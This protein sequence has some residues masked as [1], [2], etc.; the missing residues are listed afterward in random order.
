MKRFHVYVLMGNEKLK[1][2]IKHFQKYTK[3]NHI[4]SS[5]DENTKENYFLPSNHLKYRRRS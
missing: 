1:K 5:G 4:S 2:I 3:H